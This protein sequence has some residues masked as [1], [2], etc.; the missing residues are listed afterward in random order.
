MFYVIVLTYS[1]SN[2]ASEQRKQP[3]SFWESSDQ[4]KDGND[5]TRYVH[6]NFPAKLVTER[7]NSN[8]THE[9]ANKNHGWSNGA[10]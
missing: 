1:K 9:E 10:V 5:E 2:Q 7:P 4:A 6:G 8:P 3:E